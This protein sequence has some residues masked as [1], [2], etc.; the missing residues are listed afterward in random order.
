[1]SLETRLLEMSDSGQF[2]KLSTEILRW[3]DQNYRSVI[4]TGVNTE[5]KPIRDPVDGLGV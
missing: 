1:M 3:S 4:Q 2:E 5:G